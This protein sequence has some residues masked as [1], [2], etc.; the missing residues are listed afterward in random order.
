MITNGQEVVRQNVRQAEGH[1]DKMGESS[2]LPS[3]SQEG[4]K[5]S[6]RTSSLTSDLL[7]PGSPSL[8]PSPPNGVLLI[9]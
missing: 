5:G 8:F 3:A 9:H 6:G 2:G 7:K 1:K 4:R